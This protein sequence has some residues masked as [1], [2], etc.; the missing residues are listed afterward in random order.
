M[1]GDGDLN[2]PVA[3]PDAYV[4]QDGEGEDSPIPDDVLLA[5]DAAP[6]PGS[7]N[8]SS[9]VPAAASS[10]GRSQQGDSR[11]HSSSRGG[12]VNVHETMPTVVRNFI[13]VLHSY[14]KQENVFEIRKIYRNSFNKLTENYFANSAW[15]PVSSV[16]QLV[17][18]D[19]VFL[20]LYRE[21][22]FRHVYSRLKPSR[23][24]RF[25]SWENYTLFFDYLLNSETPQSLKLPTPWLWDIVDEF[26]YQFQEFCQYRSK[27]KNKREDEITLLKAN[28]QVCV[29][30][31]A[32][33]V[34]LSLSLLLSLN[35]L[36][37]LL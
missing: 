19:Q 28:P 27:L 31:L 37:S 14:V 21:L 33:V 15:P 26:I 23:Q 8:F 18:Q 10:R 4:Y 25:E 1:E 16:A 35:V 30:R 12:Q 29:F 17:D 2:I 7:A 36:I 6:I 20:M 9:S 5:G 24:N 22:Y 3:L 11:R 13:L 32:N 34:A